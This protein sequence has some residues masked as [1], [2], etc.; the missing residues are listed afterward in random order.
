[1]PCEGR[2]KPHDTGGIICVHKQCLH[3]DG[4]SDSHPSER[5]LLLV[6]HSFRFGLHGWADLQ[7]WLAQKM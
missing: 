3:Q 5:I 6:G 4:S 1:V 2:S 7:V